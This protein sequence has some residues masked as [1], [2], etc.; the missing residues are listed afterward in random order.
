MTLLEILTFKI[1][2]AIAK[3]V[4]KTWLKDKEVAQDIGI[5]IIDILK[6]KTQDAI[7]IQK[8]KRQF[9]ELGERAA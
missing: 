7:A 9:E 1:G 8:G 6:S 2:P 3:H 5:E 4:L